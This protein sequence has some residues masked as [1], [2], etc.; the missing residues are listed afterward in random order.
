L[1]IILEINSLA[2]EP[3]HL[4]ACGIGF[5]DLLYRPTDKVSVLMLPSWKNVFRT[6]GPIFDCL[7]RPF[8]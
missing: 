7:M 1:T 5:Y 4:E 3:R 8:V 2:I 6:V